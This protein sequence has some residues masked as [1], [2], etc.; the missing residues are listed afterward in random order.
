VWHTSIPLVVVAAGMLVMAAFPVPKVILLGFGLVYFGSNA[1]LPVFWCVP[2]ALLRGTAAA[3][4]S[5][6]STRSE[7]SAASS[8]RRCWAR[9][10]FRTGT[11]TSGLIVLSVCAFLSALLILRFSGDMRPPLTFC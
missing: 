10:G 3:G 6:S 11:F 4:G 2:S 5:R 8:R 1:F 7:T 9:S